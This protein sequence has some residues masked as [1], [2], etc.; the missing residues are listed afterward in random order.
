VR[1]FKSIAAVVPG[2]ALAFVNQ[3]VGLFSRTPIPLPKWREEANDLATAIGV[4]A[5]I[6]IC[7]L[8]RNREKSE[9]I[10]RGKVLFFTTIGLIIL[11]AALL[12]WL[13]RPPDEY[14]NIIQEVLKWLYVCTLVFV[15]ATI[16][17]MALSLDESSKVFWTV[18]I[19]SAVVVVLIGAY[20]VW[21]AVHASATCTC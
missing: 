7:I 6:G 8:W 20:F 16:A 2:V 5:A 13:G 17:M 10:I 21:R 9:L 3:W 15:I 18:V 12:F 19:A 11:C 14:T 4:F 1:A